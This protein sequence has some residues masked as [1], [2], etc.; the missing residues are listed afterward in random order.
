MSA[1]SQTAPADRAASLQ[2]TD[3]QR[4]L[5][6][7]GER[8]RRLDEPLD[9][10]LAAGEAVGRHLGVNR[11]GY[12]EVEGDTLVIGR[13]WTDG[14]V[15]HGT[16]RRP[17]GSF[18]KPITDQL[19]RG[20][21]QR[22]VDSYL[23]PL[24][25]PEQRPAFD[26][27]SLRATVTVPL[28]KNGVLVAMLSAHQKH[29]R[30]W[31][32][33]EVQLIE[34]VAER[35]WA[36]LERA[37]AEIRSR[38]SQALLA[39]FVENAP[40][41]MYLKDAEG[42][43]V[44]ANA[45]MERVFGRA[46][47]E[48]LGRTDAELLDASLVALAAEED[49]RAR[50][51]GR[52]RL[53]EQHLAAEDEEAWLMGLRFRV[54]GD[55][56]SGGQLGGFVLDITEQKRAEAALERSREALF[57]TEKLTALGSLLAG[58]SHEL[59]NP[60]AVVV[61]QAMLLEEDAQDTPLAARAAKIRAAAE[62]CGRIVQTFLAMARQKA[63]VRTAVDANA[64]IATALDL[65]QYGL[66]S[67]GVTIER[68]LAADLPALWGDADQLHQVLVN[69][70]VNAQQALEQ[71]AQPRRLVVRSCRA[72]EPGL[73][74]I[75]IADNGPGVSAEL[76]RR[77]FE[78]FFT[79]KSKAGGTGLGLSFSHAVVE[80]H[81]GRIELTDLQPGALFRITLQAAAEGSA[82]IAEIP[83]GPLGLGRRA[84]VV[85]DE[86]EILEMISEILR[87]E[88]LAVTLAGSG[89]EAIQRLQES[90]F[91]LV[92]SDLRMPD[93]GG[94]ELY[95]WIGRQRPELL[96]RTGFMTGDTLG[97]GAAEFL[98]E[99]GRPCLE[100]PFTPEAVRAALSALG[101][102]AAAEPGR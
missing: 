61:G 20:E 64:L 62:R 48:A 12:A 80:A 100:K 22:I 88:G 45:G 9:I 47:R 101:L 97:H 6:T 77:I 42:R 21:T 81:G 1:G 91:D 15:K 60:L 50:R 96:P 11:C 52:S 102:V 63:P 13:D 85:D 58:V 76:R 66:R 74:V 55:D 23:D 89:R 24:V 7:L 16:G 54:G 86:P 69:L 8:L 57:Q 32:D 25:G 3:N 44:M 56:G 92:L 28:V 38:E 39:A 99:V 37:R 36:A 46:A 72:V 26:E 79:T 18:G 2:V 95:D 65:T 17:I 94:P 35:T 14:T 78:P 19:L 53:L 83:R 70:L 40:V 27:M 33:D 84:L 98:A 87:R 67:A 90:D 43:Y 51:E 59:N 82:E 5:L 34:E 10:L 71:V 49:A 31:R 29:P 41:G 30:V 68:E 93:L 4:F 73:V 75:E